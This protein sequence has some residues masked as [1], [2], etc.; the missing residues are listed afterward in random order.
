MSGDTII[1]IRTPLTHE[2]A[3][4][5]HIGERVLLSGTILAAR[6]AAHKRLVETLDRGE[7]L[8]TALQNQIIYYV[9]PLSLIHI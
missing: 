3:R 9:G 5:L 2:T 1:R 8:P 6:D 7:P 4:G